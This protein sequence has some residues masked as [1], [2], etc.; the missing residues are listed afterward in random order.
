[1]AQRKPGKLDYHAHERKDVSDIV[2][3]ED[4]QLDATVYTQG[5]WLLVKFEDQ[6][7]AR[8]DLTKL[9][10]HLMHNDPALFVD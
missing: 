7:A 2:L 4:G 10:P 5:D 3:E 8:I 6:I 9:I 1:M